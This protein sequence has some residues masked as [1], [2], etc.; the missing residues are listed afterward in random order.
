L[1]D[2]FEGHDPL[3]HAAVEQTVFGRFCGQLADGR[4]PQLD[5]SR[6]QAGRFQKGPG[7]TDSRRLR[8]DESIEKHADHKGLV[9]TNTARQVHPTQRRRTTVANG[10]DMT[11]G[12]L[13][14]CIDEATHILEAAYLPDA[15]RETLATAIGDA[16]AALGGDTGDDEDD[17]YDDDSDDEDDSDNDDSDDEDDS[18]DDSDDEDVISEKSIALP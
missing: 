5:G 17:S 7:S 15:N 13:Q 4:Q 11:K 16:L 10:D 1:A 14:D 2:A 12:D 6:S 8:E 18:D 3:G 9:I